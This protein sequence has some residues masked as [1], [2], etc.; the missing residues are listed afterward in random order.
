MELAFH[1]FTL[2]FVAKNGLTIRKLFLDI[3][4]RHQHVHVFD[5]H[6]DRSRVQESSAFAGTMTHRFAH[7][8]LS[9]FSE[10]IR[11][12]SR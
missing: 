9:E 4:S 2:D 5:R 8:G 3:L 7:P 1:N 11:V 12:S 6:L 10:R